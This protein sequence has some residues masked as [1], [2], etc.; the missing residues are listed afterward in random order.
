MPLQLMAVKSRLGHAETGAG[1]LGIFHASQHLSGCKTDAVT[2]LRTLNP[3]VEGVLSTH[4]AKLHVALP[5]QD[6]PAAS[7]CTGISSFAFQVGLCM[8]R[9]S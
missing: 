7:Q 8:A 1:V 2:H 5:R 6:A 9:A 4:A 3:H